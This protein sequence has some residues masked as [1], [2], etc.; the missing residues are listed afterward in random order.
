MQ[1]IP[2][3]TRGDSVPPPTSDVGAKPNHPTP[4][5]AMLVGIAL[6]V[7]TSLCLRWLNGPVPGGMEGLGPT[8]VL[9]TLP[10]SVSFL[11][12]G[13]LA[14]AALQPRQ[15]DLVWLARVVVLL[16]L[17]AFVTCLVAASFGMV[18][19]MVVV[20]TLNLQKAGLGP[21]VLV[22]PP[23][24]IGATLGAWVGFRVAMVGRRVALVVGTHA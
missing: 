11:A 3:G 10:G 9:L 7:V 18:V 22:V 24:V 19:V 12:T 20:E 5:W 1:E 8:L 2:P 16:P 14:R 6:G 4:W 17:V 15:G 23:A 21:Q 13:C